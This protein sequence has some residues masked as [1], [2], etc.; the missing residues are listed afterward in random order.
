LAVLA[1]SFEEGCYRAY[2]T[3]YWLSSLRISLPYQDTYVFLDHVSLTTVAD[4]ADTLMV[5]LPR[6]REVLGIVEGLLERRLHAN[7]INKIDIIHFEFA[8]SPIK[9]DYRRILK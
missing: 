9:I 6:A 7:K 1:P 5:I 4:I 2:K 3:S 8:L